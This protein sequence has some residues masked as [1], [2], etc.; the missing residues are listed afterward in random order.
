MEESQTGGKGR[1]VPKSRAEIKNE[2]E[3]AQAMMNRRRMQVL[4]HYICG[5]C[6]PRQLGRVK[7]NK[8][9]FYIACNSLA[10]FGKPVYEDRFVKRQHG[11]VSV[12]LDRVLEELSDAGEIE[13]SWVSHYGKDKEEYAVLKAGGL[14]NFTVEEKALIDTVIERIAEGHTAKSISEKT[15]DRIW[16]LAEEG[17]EIPLYTV[18]M[19]KTREITEAERAWGLRE[20]EKAKAGKDAESNGG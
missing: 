8:I 14:K 9:L 7:L 12:S 4:V 6:K 3:R 16:R 10:A 20:Y 13:V 11:P 18:F 15:H 17:E 5:K 2:T 19:S 1:A